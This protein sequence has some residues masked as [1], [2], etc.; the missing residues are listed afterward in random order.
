L[1]RVRIFRVE[2][3]IDRET[4]KPVTDPNTG[5]PKTHKVFPR[6]HVTR[7][8][9]ATLLLMQGVHPR[10]VQELL[11]HSSIAV[12]MDVYSHVVPS[13]GAEAAAKMDALLSAVEKS[14]GQDTVAKL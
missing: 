1:E 11:G 10:V 12:T 4:G 9:A 6:F 7:H 2:P 3:V 14:A 5:Q 13:M 8:T